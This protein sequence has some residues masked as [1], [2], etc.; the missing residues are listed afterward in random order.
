MNEIQIIVPLSVFNGAE[1]LTPETILERLHNV[2]V[3]KDRLAQSEERYV[4]LVKAMISYGNSIQ[5]I[6]NEIDNP[7]DKAVALRKLAAEMK[8]VAEDAEDLE[9]QRNSLATFASG[10]SESPPRGS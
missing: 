6:L 2:L 9:R 3:L 1:N 4:K 10:F 8:E 5:L 7:F